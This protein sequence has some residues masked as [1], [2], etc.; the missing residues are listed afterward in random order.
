MSN[1][2]AASLNVA[3]SI[4][5]AAAIIISAKY[6]N[7]GSDFTVTG[8]LIAAWFVPFWTLSNWNGQNSV[9]REI[10]CL[11]RLFSRNQP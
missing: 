2:Q 6:L 5:F 1:R 7:F 11:R 10:N 3:I 4:L 9:A 8:L